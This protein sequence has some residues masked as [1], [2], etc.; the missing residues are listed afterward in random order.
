MSPHLF[1]SPNPRPVWKI[2]ALQLPGTY[3]ARPVLLRLSE[4]E[5]AAPPALSPC[6]FNFAG[7][8]VAFFFYRAHQPSLPKGHLTSKN[9]TPTPP[10]HRNL[11]HAALQPQ[12]LPFL[13]IKRRKKFCSP[14][15]NTTPIPSPSSP[16]SPLASQPLHNG[17]NNGSLL[18][19]A[20]SGSVR[21]PSS[22]MSP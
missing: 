7:A 14:S 16:S 3:L 20:A 6:K 1:F 21:A 8:L 18:A 11:H 9:E 13:C 5:S 17:R 10:Q 2:Q 4:L 12:S 15:C 19:R 22:P